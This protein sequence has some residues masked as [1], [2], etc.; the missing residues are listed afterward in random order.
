MSHAV[1]RSI[2][3]FKVTQHPLRCL[4]EKDPCHLKKSIFDRGDATA[5]TDPSDKE[6][7]SWE[8]P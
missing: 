8:K 2:K 6:T 1:E 4:S 3:L 7:S 5:D